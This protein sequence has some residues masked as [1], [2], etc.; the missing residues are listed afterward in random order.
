MGGFLRMQAFSGGSDEQ[1]VELVRKRYARRRTAAL[2][3]A[4]AGLG[5][6]VACL[7]V[8][9]LVQEHIR[10]M[11]PE[12]EIRSW[13]LLLFSAMSLGLLSGWLLVAGFRLVEQ[14]LRGFTVSRMAR[15]L[16]QYHDELAK[17]DASP[18]PPPPAEDGNR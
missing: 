6:I 9:N 13:R 11:F 5:L 7:L 3:F 18:S 2:L 14:S 10:P 1:F 12:M 17:R 8:I 4:P 16:V 15:L